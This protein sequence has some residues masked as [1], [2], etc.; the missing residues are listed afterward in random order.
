MECRSLHSRSTFIAAILLAFAQLAVGQC[1]PGEELLTIHVSADGVCRF[2]DFSS[3]CALLGGNLIATHHNHHVELAFEI[4]PATK[5]EVVR[6][7]ME[8]L[9]RAGI[10]KI[11]CVNN[12][13]F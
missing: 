10:A 11:G 3:P 2:L 9:Q 1:V 5:Y 7:M 8:S 6:A 4:D 12:E 13:I